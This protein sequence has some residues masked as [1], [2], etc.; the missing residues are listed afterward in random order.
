MATSRLLQWKWRPHAECWGQGWCSISGTLGAHCD[1]CH[2]VFGQ[3]HSF[4]PLRVG[5]M[6]GM[7]HRGCHY[8]SHDPITGHTKGDLWGVGPWQVLCYM[9]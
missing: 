8:L 3:L 5:C 2:L 9:G 4:M 7:K 1:R 6:V